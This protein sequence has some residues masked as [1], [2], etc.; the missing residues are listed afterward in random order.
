MAF[1]FRRRVGGLALGV[2]GVQVVRFASMEKSESHTLSTAVTQFLLYDAMRIGSWWAR[3]RHDSD[4]DRFA[5]V[6][7]ALLRSRLAANAETAYGRDHG[8]GKILAS[9]DL[10]QQFRETHPLTWPSHYKGYTERIA[11]GEANVMNA[12]PEAMLAATSGTSGTRNLLPYTPTMRKEFFSKGILVVFDTLLRT[13]PEAFSSLQRTCKL[14]FAPVMESS[15]GG[16]LIGPNSSGP[17]DSSF[18]KLLP[19]YSTPAEGYA[20]ANAEY[21]ALYVHALFAARDRKLGLVEAN[22]VSLPMRLMR[23]VHRDGLA[24]AADIEAGQIVNEAVAARIDPSLLAALN[25][26][27]GGPRPER[28]A[29][30]RAALAPPRGEQ[31]DGV[32]AGDGGARKGLA[33]RIWPHLRVFNANGTGAFASYSSQIRDHEGFGVP[34]ISTLLAASEGLMGVSLHQPG[35]TNAAHAPRESGETSFCLVPGAMFFEFLPIQGGGGGGESGENGGG[36]ES[37]GENGGESGGRGAADGGEKRPAV[38]GGTLLA[39]EVVVGEDYE[40]VI[41]NLGGLCRYRIGDVVKVV[42]FHKQAPLVE[43]R[44]RIGQLLNLRGE[45]LSEPQFERALQTALGAEGGKQGKATP[46]SGLSQALPSRPRQPPVVPPARPKVEGE[47][48]V[49]EESDVEP[50]RYC[51][52]YEPSA[53]APSSVSRGGAAAP[54]GRRSSPPGPSSAAPSPEIASRLD[55]ALCEESPVYA[56]WRRKRAIGQGVVHLVPPGGFE[57]LRAQRLKEGTS[58][59]QLKVSRVLRKP[60]HVALL[61]EWR[62]E[63]SPSRGGGAA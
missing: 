45:K 53:G 30:I 39:D 28:A 12:E 61:R 22:F 18:K 42:G 4:C 54:S 40:L 62:G 21:A 2:A 47:Y 13:C 25:E 19:L 37:G 24:L 1:L 5:D 52:F 55:A 6:Q 58:P 36:G 34:I 10:V 11:N 31:A 44:Y 46:P 51:I 26:Q 32:D 15:P 29:E 17:K 27:L 41:T 63:P 8:F 60:T 14:A 23:L 35:P 43:F 48:A 56:T 3:G 59:T 38:L 20:I 16:L 50:P 33:R 7:A 9:D 49:V 57:A